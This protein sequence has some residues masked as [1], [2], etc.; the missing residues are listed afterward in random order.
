MDLFWVNPESRCSSSNSMD[1]HT[2]FSV[3]WWLPSLYLL[4]RAAV[5]V[6][7]P[8]RGELERREFREKPK[9]I[10]GQSLQEETKPFQTVFIPFPSITS[11]FSPISS[12]HN[13]FLLIKES[14]KQWT[15][16]EKYVDSNLLQH[17]GY[18]SIFVPSQWQAIWGDDKSTHLKP[19][20]PE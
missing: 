9:N 18:L 19:W 3:F 10:A 5:M 4:A 20:L 8:Q 14:W 11:F 1:L 2:T 7:S 15:D 13:F 12:P 6:I 16:Q 17:P